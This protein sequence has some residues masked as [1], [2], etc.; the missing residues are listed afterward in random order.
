MSGVARW[1]ERQGGMLVA[2]RRT[3]AA[4]AQDDGARDGGW[5]LL[6]WLLATGVLDAFG[7]AAKVGALRNFDAVIGG[8]AD[9]A[10]SLLPPFVATFAI[11]LVLGTTRAY[12]AGSCLAPMIAIGAAGRLAEAA[13]LWRPS[14]SWLP[15]AIAAAA[16]LAL[17]VYV[18]PVVP[19]RAAE[20]R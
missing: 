7:A 14:P 1:I 13:G 3:A 9:L 11:E 12:R 2:P 15:A 8:A 5:A 10:M 6:A 16:A 18:R 4:L 19:E 20:A 17:A